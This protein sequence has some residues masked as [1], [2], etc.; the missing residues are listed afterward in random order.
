MVT[1][2]YEWLRMINARRTTSWNGVET[3][4]GDFDVERPRGV[5]WG[6]LGD[7][8]FQSGFVLFELDESVKSLHRATT[9][10]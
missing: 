3:K 8:V 4:L 1:N 6:E 10:A 7:G 9:G 5:F 2:G